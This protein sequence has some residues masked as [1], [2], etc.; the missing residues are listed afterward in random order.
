MSDVTGILILMIALTIFIW[1]VRKFS[2]PR[3]EYV[4][5]QP[6]GKLFL[7]TELSDG[8]FQSIGHGFKFV[9][10]TKD[11]VVRKIKEKFRIR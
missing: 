8:G 2:K 3:T 7:I 9:G 4:D 10:S 11:E 1:L 6:E 5:V